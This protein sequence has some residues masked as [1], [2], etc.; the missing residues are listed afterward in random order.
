MQQESVEG[1]RATSAFAHSLLRRAGLLSLRGQY[2]FVAA[3]VFLLL[4]G[5]AWFTQHTVTTATRDGT[6]RLDRR[7]HMRPTLLDFRNTLRHTDAAFGDYVDS[8]DIGQRGVATAAVVDLHRRV[9][10]LSREPWVA[11]DARRTANVELLAEQLDAAKGTDYMEGDWGHL[12]SR[13]QPVIDSAWI[14]LVELESELQADSARDVAAISTV[15]ERANKAIWLITGTGIL[16]LAVGYV[17]FEISVRGPLWRLVAALQAEASGIRSGALRSGF[18][19]EMRHL[20]SAFNLMSREVHSRQRRLQTILDNA[21]EGIMTFDRYGIVRSVNHAAVKLFEFPESDMV[22]K[23]LNLFIRNETGEPAA[24]AE[25]AGQEREMTGCRKGGERFAMALKVSAMTLEGETLYTALVGDISDRKAMVEHLKNVAEHDGVTGLYNRS[26]FQDELERVVERARR[27]GQSCAL[28]YI[29]LDNF[30]YVND[31][32][33]HAAGDRLLIEV[34]GLL[35]KRA[36]KSDLLARFGG[37]EFTVLL[38]DVDV[39]QAVTAATSFRTTLAEYP[40]VFSGQRV[41]LACSIGIAP[42]NPD[43]ESAAAIMSQADVACHLA[44]RSGRNR[45]HMYDPAAQ[46]DL[47]IMTLDMGWSRRIREA[48]EHDGFALARQPIVNVATGELEYYEV[49]LRM[50]DER[51]GLIMPGGFLPVAERFGYAT[52][53]DRWVVTHAI[54]LLA[55]HRRTQPRLRYALN[56]SGQTLTRTDICDLIVER[57]QSTGL[58]P[59]A[60]TFEVTETVAIADMSVAGAFLSRLKHI[61]CHTLL[62]DFGSGMSSFAYLRDLP[63]DGVKIDGRF[64]RSLATNTIDQAMVRAMNEVAHALGKHTIAEFVEDQETM[65]LLREFGVDYAQGYYIGR[66]MM[67][68]DCPTADGACYRETG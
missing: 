19:D 52:D 8:A 32:L 14:M 27:T 39:E 55:E 33:G 15:A 63:V 64:V 20:T 36:R 26:Y 41:D 68:T 11:D 1:R 53:I 12:R 43:V 45:V 58:D 48:I 31:T 16:L 22:G 7:Q 25:P 65:T 40:F 51:K 37:D 44:K 47:A 5:V 42:I 62:D 34:A 56:L 3:A 46:K 60:L 67:I 4:V 54:E 66:P 30:K 35:H 38:Y 28:L 49:L 59:Q 17:M 50:C 6:E 23:H 18:T 29:D 2:L 61:G 9:R 13:I 57:L 10:A 24:L 21:A